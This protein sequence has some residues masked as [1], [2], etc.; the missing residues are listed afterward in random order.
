MYKTIHWALKALSRYR[1]LL[2][3]FIYLFLHF[4]LLCLAC[5]ESVKFAYG[6]SDRYSNALGKPAFAQFYFR[7]L[8]FGT[9]PP[10]LVHRLTRE[11]GDNPGVDKP[12]PALASP[13]GFGGQ[14]AL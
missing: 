6:D 3:A 5:V 13:V 10:G 12:F 11:T 8:Y 4:A 1:F 14:N 9:T 2:V 7:S